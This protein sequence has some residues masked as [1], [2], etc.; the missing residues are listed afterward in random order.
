MMDRPSQAFTER[1][2]ELVTEFGQDLSA[3]REG[4]RE[5]PDADGGFSL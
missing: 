5:L 2:Q 3:A 1:A 4:P